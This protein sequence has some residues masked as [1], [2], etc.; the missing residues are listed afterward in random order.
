M[1]NARLIMRLVICMASRGTIGPSWCLQNIDAVSPQI[2]LHLHSSK[3][4]QRSTS[5]VVVRWAV[6]WSTTR[7]SV[8][9]A[10]EEW[11]N[12]GCGS[13][14]YCS[15]D[16]DCRGEDTKLANVSH[17]CRRDIIYLGTYIQ[18]HSISIRLVS[19]WWGRLTYQKIM[20]AL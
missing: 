3:P 12:R 15:I 18:Q 16:L 14:H 13:A 8:E 2:P 4:G 20:Y 9:H 11:L 19:T 7:Y 6:R 5:A 17:A 1:G 10:F